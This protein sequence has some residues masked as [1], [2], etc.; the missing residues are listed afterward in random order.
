MWAIFQSRNTPVNI[1][2][3]FTHH[4]R[5]GF[6]IRN[7]YLADLQS[8]RRLQIASISATDCKSVASVEV[9]EQLHIFGRIA[10]FLISC[11]IGNLFFAVPIHA[12]S[13]T[14]DQRFGVVQ[15]FDDFAATAEAGVGFTR[16]KFYWDIIQ[17]N[18]PDDW[19][20]ANV[21][22]PL[23]ATDLAA[24][25]EVV[26]LIIRTPAW[27]RD[28]N[29]SH[30]NPAQPT[31]KDV[32]DM[33]AWGSFTHRL[34]AQ[35]QGRI[36]HW[37][38]WNEPDVWD[39]NHP[40]STWNGTEQDYINL[41]KTAYLNLKAV[42]PNAKVYLS[43]LT[44]FWD[45]EYQQ[46]QYLSRL[47]AMIAT[48]PTAQAHN[49][50]FD[51]VIYHLYYKPQMIYD[52]LSE[53]R[54]MLEVYGLGDKAIWL[55]ETNAPPS[56]DPLEPPLHEPRFKA[57]LDEQSAF[58]IQIHALAFA[59]GAERVQ[60]YKLYNS[61]A[62]LEDVQPFGLLR[63]DKS[64]RPAFA[65]YQ[66]VTTYLAGFEKA[67]LFRQGEVSM[68]VFTYSSRKTTTVLWNWATTPR[69][70]TV[71]A[72]A[73]EGQLVNEIGQGQKIMAVHGFYTLDLPAATCSGGECFIGGAP[74]LIVEHATSPLGYN[75]L[76][77]NDELPAQSLNPSF[78]KSKRELFAIGF[79]GSI[80]AGTI[81]VGLIL[82]FQ[83]IQLP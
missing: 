59:A 40:G 69:Q 12:Q 50:Y 10:L 67:V 51:G 48:D 28:L 60:I 64:H 27:A 53:V 26:G 14:L 21:P 31:A 58:I 73:Q 75:A 65:A 55:N 83:K 74:R 5:C 76:I 16:I 7:G 8:A 82:L 56:S 79:S 9:G 57:T 66:T 49:F 2:D 54:A 80:L 15:T 17:P 33:A 52:I 23:I 68:V 20:P 13:P 78:Y 47:L 1:F 77:I 63:G 22:D 18:G 41:L 37:I 25:R 29:N 70:V 35:Y 36:H 24:G 61:S 11:F 4:A 38:I 43:G 32:P 45:Y 34:A 42:D 3:G 6:V 19:Q 39:S 72:R 71:K 44:Y 46:E 30:N 81:T 62:H